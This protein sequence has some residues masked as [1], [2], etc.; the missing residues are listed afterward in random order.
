MNDKQITKPRGIVLMSGGMD[1]CVLAAIAVHEC[2]AAALHISYGQLTQEREKKAFLEITD[3]LGIQDR[4][5]VDQS[6]LGRIGGSALTDPSIPL[7]KADLDSKVIPMS[8]VPFRN[9]NFLSLAVSWAEA[10][11]ADRIYI[12]AV[13][14][15]SSGYPDCRPE[16][17]RIFNQLIEAGTRP[18]TKMQILTP[19]IFLRKHEIIKKG[20]EI[21]APLHLSWSCY[22]QNEVACGV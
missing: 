7:R 11:G 1:S 13:E 15:D 19:L 22:Q 10:S 9:A 12:G 3:Y 20:I 21:K 18:E 14:P 5:A 4:L 8:Y 17:Y 6:Y 2:H 16:Y